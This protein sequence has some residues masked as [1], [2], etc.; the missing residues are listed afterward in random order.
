MAILGL[1]GR[2]EPNQS[3]MA[4]ARYGVE[5]KSWAVESTVER[6]RASQ[7]GQEANTDIEASK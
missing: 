7:A 5:S 6:T 4:G 2:G 3:K 1:A